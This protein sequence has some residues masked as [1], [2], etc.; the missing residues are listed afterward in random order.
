MTERD[1]IA[2]KV[3]LVLVPIYVGR[4]QELIPYLS[5]LHIAKVAMIAGLVALGLSVNTHS[6][7]E[8]RLFSVPQVKIILVLFILGLVGLPFGGSMGFFFNGLLKLLLFV[9]LLIFFTSTEEALVKVLWSFVLSIVMLAVAAT[10]APSMMNGRVYATGTYDP[11]DMALTLVVAMPLMYYMMEQYGGWKKLLL[12][13]GMFL[14]L[15]IIIKTGSRGGFLALVAA[16]GAVFFEK[17]VTFTL[18]RLPLILII[19]MIVLSM[20]PQEQIHRLTTMF[21]KDYNTTSNKGRED[22]WKRGVTI[23][24]QNPLLGCGI[25]KF[26]VANSSLH[27]GTW[28]AAHNA[29]LQMGAELGIPGLIIFILL[30]RHSFASLRE[31][32]GI[33]KNTWIV[34]G[35]RAGFIGLCVGMMFLSWAYTCVTYFMFGICIVIRKLHLRIQAYA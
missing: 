19:G 31:G 2:F 26:D 24:L 16:A 35:L 34:D 1:S 29:Y 9:Y 25:N 3:I 11:N 18:K 7:P 14:A 21:D 10:V 23:M 22:I 32:A 17:G 5:G 12:M 6:A 13:G 20:A 15:V 33:L 30:I 4:V 8:E 28:Q 27:G